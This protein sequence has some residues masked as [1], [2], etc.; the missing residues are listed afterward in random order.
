M[1]RTKPG[2]A[3][4]RTLKE[5]AKPA[6][7]EVPEP[8]EIEVSLDQQRVS[9][10]V[11]TPKAEGSCLATVDVEIGYLDTD[12]DFRRAGRTRHVF[13]EDAGLGGPWAAVEAAIWTLIDAESE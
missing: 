11:I 6:V 7:V 9:R 1:P 10:V 2:T 5:Q 13:K 12:G 3:E 8:T 4:K